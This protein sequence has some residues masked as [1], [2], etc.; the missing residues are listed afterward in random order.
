MTRVAE[1]K[2]KIKKGKIEVMTSIVRSGIGDK[3]F[4]LKKGKDGDQFCL[5]FTPNLFL[6]PL[7]L[8]FVLQHLSCVS[9]TANLFSI[10]NA[11]LEAGSN[12]RY[13]SI[14]SV[15]GL[16]DRESQQAR[17]EFLAEVGIVHVATGEKNF[18][19]V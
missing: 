4:F 5:M 3:N 6:Y 18:L 16:V 8:F 11:T 9:D 7:T 14:I 15:A 12:L 1:E 17:Y 10:S 2:W 13:V 19:S